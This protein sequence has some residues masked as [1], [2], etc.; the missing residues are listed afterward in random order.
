[1]TQAL[2]DKWED[3]ALSTFI[4]VY[5]RQ[6]RRTRAV[7]N[8]AEREELRSLIADLYR[9][10]PEA[11]RLQVQRLFDDMVTDIAQITV[12]E[13]PAPTPDYE[14]LTDTILKLSAENAGRFATEISNNSLRLSYS[15]IDNW[16]EMPGATVQDLTARMERIWRGPRPATA[17]TTETTRLYNATRIE[18]FREMGA[19]GFQPV[20]RNDDRVR[21][22][23]VRYAA[24]GPYP[25]DRTDRIPPY[26]D[27]NCRCS[28]VAVFENPNGV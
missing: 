13:V 6:W 4:D 14:R 3:L 10:E 18:T 26:G 25:L 27:V 7:I 28:I 5:L 17:A 1:M 12:D 23:H 21:E 8:K 22:S 16:L 20:T 24:E 2:R 19:W 9:R 15:V 11:V